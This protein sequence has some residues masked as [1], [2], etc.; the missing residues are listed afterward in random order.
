MVERHE[1]DIFPLLRRRALFSGADNFA[2]FDLRRADGYVDE[3]VFAYTN[4]RG[5][6]RALVLYNNA[7]ASTAGRIHISSAINV[8]SADAPHLVQRTLSEAL[9]LRDDDRLF[10]AFRDVIAG[11]EYL[12]HCRELRDGCDVQLHGYQYQVF[13][14]WR[15]LVDEDHGWTR[16]HARLSGRPVPSLVRARRELELESVLDDLERGLR[17]ELPRLLPTAPANAAAT[18]APRGDASDPATG[19]TATSRS[20]PESAEST[21][22]AEMKTGNEAPEPFPWSAYHAVPALPPAALDRLREIL[23]RVGGVPA[24]SRSSSAPPDERHRSSPRPV[25]PVTPPPLDAELIAE[26]ATQVLSSAAPSDEAGAAVWPAVRL[27]A[28]LAWRPGLLASAGARK[29]AELVA[30]LAE[31]PVAI[32]YLQINRHDGTLYLRREN[33]EQW[34]A[35]EVLLADDGRAASSA[36]GRATLAAASQADYRLLELARRLDAAATDLA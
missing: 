26:R 36:L 18:G 22:P 16:L 29:A 20:A 28:L 12:R 31:D 32:A 1:R 30:A 11:V 27:A 7:Y 3:N 15:E 13:L 10:Y 5:D 6:D 34:I 24:G 21:A 35:A 17:A 4:R 14:D 8:G 25:A 2:L 23:A 19:T 9:G 33:L